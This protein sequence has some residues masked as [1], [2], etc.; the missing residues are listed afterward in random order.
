VSGAGLSPLLFSLLHAYP[1]ARLRDHLAQW[2]PI[3]TCREQE[4]LIAEG[5]QR[6]DLIY[7][8]QVI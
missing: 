5:Q 2:M 6:S 3:V 8:V 1:D 4:R 7:A